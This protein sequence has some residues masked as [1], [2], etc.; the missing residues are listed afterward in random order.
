VKEKKTLSPIRKISCDKD[1]VHT[2]CTKFRPH[3]TEET[4]VRPIVKVLPY[5]TLPS[6][7]RDASVSTN[8]PKIVTE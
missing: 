4:S 5:S 2:S 1:V 6:Q 8:E 3:A 7:D